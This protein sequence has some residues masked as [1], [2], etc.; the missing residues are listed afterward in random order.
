MNRALHDYVNAVAYQEPPYTNALELE[1]RLRAVDSGASI[2]YMI[3][4]M[5]DS[6]TLYENRALEAS[7]RPLG[8]GKYEVKLKV[9]ARKL[10]ADESGGGAAG[11][12]GGLDR[13]RGVRCEGEAAVHGASQD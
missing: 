5:F 4:D 6:V 13:H 11:R 10:K 3:D 2:A 7:Y 9:A 8:E 1:A 12:A